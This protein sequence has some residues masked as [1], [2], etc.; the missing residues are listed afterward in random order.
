MK[1]EAITPRY[2]RLLKTLAGMPKK[3]LSVHGKDNV[4]E[5]VLHE[6]CDEGCFNI[7]KAAYFIDNPDFDCIKG[8]AGFNRA[9]EYGKKE[10]M[11]KDTD[12]FS[13]HMLTCPFNQ[14]VRSVQKQSFK[15][16]G[17]S[18]EA[19]VQELSRELAFANPRFYSWQLKHD[20]H[21]I[22]VFEEP[23]DMPL[24]QDLLHGVCLLAFCPIF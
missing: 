7:T 23:T 17:M 2:E 18:D 16:N 21:G 5:L 12:S 24:D 11:W 9:N 20:N 8:V 3:M 19:I 22:F 4:T 14:Q 15:K 1:N 6:L 10:H 13:S